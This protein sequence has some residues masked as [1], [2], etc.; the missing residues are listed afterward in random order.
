[1]KTSCA[2]WTP[3]GSGHGF[4]AIL[5]L[6][7]AVVL[8]SITENAVRKDIEDKVLSPI[9]FTYEDN[10]PRFRWVD[11]FLLAAVYRNHLLNR[12]M[13]RIALDR[14]E[15][16]VAPTFRKSSVSCQMELTHLCTPIWEKPSNLIAGCG[17][18]KIDDYLF[19]DFDQVRNDLNPRVDLY[20]RGLSKIDE[21]PDTF[22]GE[23]VFK[24]TRLPV[25]HIGKMA[26]GGEPVEDILSDYPYLTLDDVAFAVIYSEA[27][28]NVGRPRSTLGEVSGEI[29]SG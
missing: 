9:R 12:K 1:M 15:V 4:R 29:S 10:K 20:A 16:C 8:A 27:H 11:V 6:R 5:S 2:E 24:N 26:A 28:P 18:M 19:L 23:A 14:L 13:R 25:R 17:A 7:E 21:K 22:G 3:I